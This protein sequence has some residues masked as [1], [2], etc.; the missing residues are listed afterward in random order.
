MNEPVDLGP[1][2]GVVWSDADEWSRR[3]TAEGCIICRSRG[4]LNIIGE[5]PTC[6]ATA[7]PDAPLRHS[8]CV[9]A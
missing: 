8:V 9:V 1:T 3:L 7:D 5:L 2:G 6:W 4:P